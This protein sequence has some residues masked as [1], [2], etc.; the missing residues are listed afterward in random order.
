MKILFVSESDYFTS[1]FIEHAK[2]LP[3]AE[4][5]FMGF[6]W[7]SGHSIRKEGFRYFHVP[8]HGK[9]IPPHR[10]PFLVEMVGK[11][12]DSKEYSKTFRN[13]LGCCRDIA[14][15]TLDKFNPD[16]VVYGTI[17]SAI[18]YSAYKASTMKGIPC[19]G[20]QTSFAKNRHINNHYG[21]HWIERIQEMKIPKSLQIAPESSIAKIEKY[22]YRRVNNN[23]AWPL[24]RIMRLSERLWRTLSG[25]IAFDT[26]QELSSLAWA[27]AF[28]RT[29]FPGVKRLD[30]LDDAGKRFIL[31]AINQ[32]CIEN[33]FT[34]AELMEFAVKAIPKGYAIVLR[35]HPNEHPFPIPESMLSALRKRNALVSQSGSGPALSALVSQCA[36]LLTMNSAVGIEALMLGKPVFTA[37]P[38]IYARPG[39]ATPISKD[40][41]RA[42]HSFLESPVIKGP[43]LS[44]TARFRHWLTEEHMTSFTLQ[45]GPEG[46]GLLHKIR[47]MARETSH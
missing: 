9:S 42:V 17:E 16:L 35:P 43:A 31:I 24:Q 12:H 47:A 36:A 4:I 33:A 32:P 11:R 7:S 15:S 45:D 46:H 27:K 8:F 29:W 44:E 3:E 14:Q 25:G 1:I 20:L 40:D 28:R 41:A 37:A 39:L 13:A 19:I 5:G 38:A 6:Y 21:E 26:V 30:T 23:K 2:Y 10:M 34:I 18:A 22:D